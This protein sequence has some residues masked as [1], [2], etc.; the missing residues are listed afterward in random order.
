MHTKGPVI[1]KYYKMYTQTSISKYRNLATI[2]FDK[3]RNSELYIPEEFV[4]QWSSNRKILSYSWILL[5]VW[6]T[7]MLTYSGNVSGIN[8]KM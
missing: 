4:F 8:I 2:A 3:K 5:H 7:E 6:I 1:F